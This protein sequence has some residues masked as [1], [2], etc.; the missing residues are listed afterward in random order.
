MQRILSVAQMRAADR[1]TIENLGIP[2]RTLMERAGE[3]VAEEIQKRFKGGRILFVCGKGNNGGDGLVAARLLKKAHGFSVF[4]LKL[5]AGEIEK[6]DLDY[7][8]V[9]DCIF[10]TGLCREVTGEMKRVIEKINAKKC[11]KLSVDIPS[12]LNG[13]SGLVM[14]AAV[15]ADM[16]VSV[17]EFKAGHFLNDGKDYCGKI[18]NKDIGIAVFEE[19]FAC[20]LEPADM[21]RFF[22]KRLENTHKGSYGRAAIVGGSKDYFGSALLSA[23]ALSALRTGAGY[24]ELYVPES[25]FSLYAGKVPEIITRTFSDEKGAICFCERDFESVLQANAVAVG[26]GMGCG[27]QTYRAVS[28]LLKHYRGA[29]VVDADGLNSLATYGVNALKNAAADVVLT[30]HVKEFSRLTG[31]GTA[32]I[33]ADPVGTA[34]EFYET[35]GVNV[36]LKSATSVLVG[37]SGVIFNTTGSSGMAKGGSGDVLSG[38]IAGIAARGFSAFDAA[39]AGAY[40]CGRAGELAAAKFNE[41]AATPSDTAAHLYAAENEIAEG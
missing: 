19:D 21:K 12:G 15:K 14:G 18:V 40:L 13:D 16:T 34:K 8:V 7:D 20:R 36:L 17:Q 32:Q 31:K 38:A 33:L 37:K 28:W 26:M 11:F 4:V 9:V 6:L 35:Y 5:A 41:Y 22:P 27:E 23:T 25:L 30:P 3:A 10:G 39:S 1:Y 24:G 2:E 29:L